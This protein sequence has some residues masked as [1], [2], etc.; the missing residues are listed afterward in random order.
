MGNSK[1]AYY[2]FPNEFLNFLARDHSQGF[3]FYPFGEVV[4]YNH[5]ILERW[6]CCR[7][8][9]Y[10]IYLPDCKRPW[11]G[12]WC[13]LL[14]VWPGNAGESLA[15]VTLP[16]EVCGIGLHRRLEISLSWGLMGQGLP[17]SMIAAD[18]LVHLLDYVV[19]FFKVNILQKRGR[20]SSLIE[21]IVK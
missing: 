16:C 1:A 19:S 20:E 11:R 6:A 18:V 17:L 14:W 5:C 13:E 10:Q 12:H 4:D 3:S 15:L 2:G 21:L 7:H 9:T 8:W